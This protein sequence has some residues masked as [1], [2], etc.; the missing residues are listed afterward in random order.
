MIV[1]EVQGL[2]NYVTSSDRRDK[3]AWAYTLTELLQTTHSLNI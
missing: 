1:W 3:E 2:S